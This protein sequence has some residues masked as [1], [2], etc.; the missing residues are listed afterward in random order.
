V[1]FLPIRVIDTA[2][3]VS[4]SSRQAIRDDYQWLAATPAHRRL[5]TAAAAIPPGFTQVPGH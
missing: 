4:Q 1:T 2:P 3:G 5:L